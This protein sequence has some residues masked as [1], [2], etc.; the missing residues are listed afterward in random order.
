LH[1]PIMIMSFY[2]GRERVLERQY[3]PR[4]GVHRPEQ[5]LSPGNSTNE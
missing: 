1:I 5:G 3:G 4:V 2:R